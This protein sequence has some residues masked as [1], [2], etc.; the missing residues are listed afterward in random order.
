MANASNLNCVFHD[1]S[2]L[3]DLIISEFDEVDSEID[4]IISEPFVEEGDVCQI[5]KLFTFVIF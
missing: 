3:Q 2:P 4:K 1:E 5:G